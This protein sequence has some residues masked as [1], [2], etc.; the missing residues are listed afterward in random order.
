VCIT[1]LV[2]HTIKVSTELFADTQFEDN[3]KFCHDAL[4]LMTAKEIVKWM[5]AKDYYKFWILP[6]YGL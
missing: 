4:S 6:E 2:E 3:W 1:D 5:E